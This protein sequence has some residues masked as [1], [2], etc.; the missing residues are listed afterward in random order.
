MP[1]IAIN[2][3]MED[4]K[5]WS[6]LDLQGTSRFAGE[7]A[8]LAQTVLSVTGM[9][10][11]AEEPIIRNALEPLVGVSDVAVNVVGKIAIIKHDVRLVSP[12]QLASI[13]N[14]A[15]L[16]AR[17]KR[18]TAREPKGG[19]PTEPPRRREANGDS[20]CGVELGG[21]RAALVAL[22]QCV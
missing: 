14:D 18:T 8:A 12:A 2:Y 3:Y 22:T 21:F 17:V 19:W 6:A 15:A 7:A 10:C 9:C 11:P 5:Q 4:K 20:F 1:L 16:G 13:L